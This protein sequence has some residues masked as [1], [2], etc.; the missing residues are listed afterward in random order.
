MRKVSLERVDGRVGGR[1]RVLGQD[2]V[3]RRWLVDRGPERRDQA[4]ERRV[5][6]RQGRRRR[7]RAG[8]GRVSAQ[9]VLD[10]EGRRVDGRRGRRCVE[11]RVRVLEL[12]GWRRPSDVSAHGLLLPCS[13]SGCD[14]RK[15]EVTSSEGADDVL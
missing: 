11:R 7:H 4:G 13:L 3:D 15:R 2:R 12:H 10:V 5:R 6:R 8:H 14:E 9:N 1:E